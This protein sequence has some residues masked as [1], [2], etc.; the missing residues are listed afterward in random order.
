M[1]QLIANDVPLNWV[2]PPPLKY[3]HYA[4]EE[5]IAKVLIQ[6]YLEWRAMVR[7]PDSERVP[8][9]MPRFIITK[10]D[11]SVEVKHGLICNAHK[12]NKYLY[13]PRFTLATM[14]TMFP[15]LRRDMWA[16]SIGIKHAYL[17]MGLNPELA[18]YV[19]IEVDNVRHCFCSGCFGLSPLSYL[20]MTI[21]N[22]ITKLAR[23]AGILMCIHL[24]N[25][26]ILGH[27]RDQ[28]RRHVQMVLHLLQQLRTPTLAPMV[29]AKKGVKGGFLN[30]V[31]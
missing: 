31:K 13:S 9:V 26:L 6:D 17:H 18:K 29:L 14:H 22:V 25:I 27:C 4:E 10:T 20:W 19:V 1:V 12:I 30:V 8:F 3:N 28:M 21:V 24:D 16:T 23:A 11:V 2:H 5:A 7:L 15:A